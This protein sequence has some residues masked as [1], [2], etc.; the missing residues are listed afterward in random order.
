MFNCASTLYKPQMCAA[1]ASILIYELLVCFVE[2]WLS[3]NGSAM[4]DKVRDSAGE[5][6]TGRGGGEAALLDQGDELVSANPPS[7]QGAD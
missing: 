4:G 6:K 5:C 3:I 7:S 1:N 2:H